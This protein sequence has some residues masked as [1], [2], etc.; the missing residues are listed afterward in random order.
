MLL[1][2]ASHR[3]TVGPIL[4]LD[5]ISLEVTL[6]CYLKGNYRF[7]CQFAV[8]FW[9]LTYQEELLFLMVLALPKAPKTG[10]AWII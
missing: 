6:T 2:S 8:Y 10:L 1:V 3:L 5:T 4:N 7:P 9:L